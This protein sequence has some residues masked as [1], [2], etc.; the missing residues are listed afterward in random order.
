L[1]QY[2]KQNTFV[3]YYQ[4]FFFSEVFLAYLP[5]TIQLFMCI[6]TRKLSTCHF[7]LSPSSNNLKFSV[8]LLR[9]SSSDLTKYKPKHV[10]G[11]NRSAELMIRSCFSGCCK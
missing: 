6:V 9:S 3:N 2:A 8:C 11:V 5:V 10:R 4:V 1:H 7:L